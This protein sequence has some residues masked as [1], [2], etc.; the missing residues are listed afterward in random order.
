[1]G[2]GLGFG[3][4]GQ[5]SG[6]RGQRS[7]ARVGVWRVARLELSYKVSGFRVH[8]WGIGFSKRDGWC[9]EGLFLTLMTSLGAQ[10][11]LAQPWRECTHVDRVGTG[12]SRLQENPHLP[13]TPLGP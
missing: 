5:G 9:N 4:R 11:A 2:Q 10:R 8:S 13:R 12:V 6:V 3:V 1:V 7:G